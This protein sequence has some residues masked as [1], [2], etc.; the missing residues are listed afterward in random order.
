MF[1]RVAIALFFAGQVLASLSSLTNLTSDIELNVSLVKAVIDSINGSSFTHELKSL[2]KSLSQFSDALLQPQILKRF[3]GNA[4]SANPLIAGILNKYQFETVNP[5]AEIIDY[6]SLDQ[7]KFVNPIPKGFS[8]SSFKDLP[9][10]AE[11]FGELIKND[12]VLIFKQKFN[13]C[14]QYRNHMKNALKKFV[15]R[16]LEEFVT[17]RVEPGLSLSYIRSYYCSIDF[18]INYGKPKNQI[19]GKK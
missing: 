9:L 12:N 4:T 17:N 18:Y 2:E 8:A 15:Y 10:L 1:V 6:R 3:C 19:L 7:S 16:R 13:D 14:V 11:E 5:F